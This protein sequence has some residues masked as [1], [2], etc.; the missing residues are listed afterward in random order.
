M[1]TLA[2][3]KTETKLVL[4]PGYLARK[5]SDWKLT[6]AGHAIQEKE[7]TF[8]KKMLLRILQRAMKVDPEAFASELFKERI[9]PFVASGEKG[10]RVNLTIGNESFL[11]NGRTRR[12]GQFR[13]T[14]L[15]DREFA[16]D[17]L[18][19]SR[20]SQGFVDCSVNINGDINQNSEGRIMVLP[21]KGLSIVS[22]IDDTIKITEV[23]NVRELL[24]N[25]FLR[26]FESIEG[27]ANVYQ[28]WQSCGAMFHYVSSS[29]WQLF[30]P[31][32]QLQV[33][34]G[35]PG[36]SIH[37]RSFRLRDQMFKRVSEARR[38]KG[39][40]IRL[41]IKNMPKR[42]F[43]LVG[44]SGERDPGIY[45]KICLR[46]PDKIRGLF[47]RQ[48][49]DRPLKAKKIFKIQNQLPHIPVRVFDHAEELA[50]LGRTLVPELKDS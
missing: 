20:K 19:E 31:L 32:V 42:R 39:G 13:G 34:G 1:T 18:A 4:Y 47:I 16:L 22:D 10:L 49:K 28:K 38:G 3:N 7:V 8:R 9:Q 25:T 37:L 21:K 45:R 40:V 2:Q 46:Y 15:F 30:E 29:P 6:I 17:L 14:V 12:N 41:L 27:M 44:D 24:A 23:G 26:D 5:K 35:F 43:L 48:V 33:E 50:E 11:L 36:G